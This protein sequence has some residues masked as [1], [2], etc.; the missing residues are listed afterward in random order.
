MVEWEGS[1]MS[2]GWI[3]LHKKIIKW[4]WYSDVN[5]CRL[6]IH[7]LLTVNF[8]EKKWRGITI[9]RG[10]IITSLPN[11]SA[12]T[13]LSVQELRTCLSKLK[14]T[15]EATCESTQRYTMIS[16]TN[17]EKYQESNTQ[18]NSLA[19]D[20]QQTSN[21][22]ATCTK[23]LKEV[24][25]VKKEEKDS[26]ESKKKTLFL[27]PDDIDSQLW[28]DFKKLRHAKKAPITQ[29]AMAAIKNE[30]D[31]AGITFAEAVKVMVEN[32]WQGFRQ[33]WYAKT[34]DAYQANKNS[35]EN[36]TVISEEFRAKF[37]GGK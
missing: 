6:F 22:R 17:Y 27:K 31:K 3:K 10:S 37:L 26:N 11:L 13:N 19:T 36:K 2:E 28:E 14:S 20:E 8:E 25:E 12:D 29:T 24:K 16:I 34:F 5:T 32:G 35:V 9:P 15:C 23:E 18:V 33:S 7:L 4:E 30:A 21:R 1:K